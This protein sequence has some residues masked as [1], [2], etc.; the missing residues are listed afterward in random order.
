MSFLRPAPSAAPRRLCQPPRAPLLMPAKALW[1][2]PPLELE[3]VWTVTPKPCMEC[4]STDASE[5]SP[6]DLMDVAH[7]AEEVEGHSY[8]EGTDA[9]FS[10]GGTAACNTLFHCPGQASAGF[11]STAQAC[12]ANFTSIGPRHFPGCKYSNMSPLLQSVFTQLTAR[13]IPPTTPH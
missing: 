5:G 11:G 13:S 7:E 4:C 2:V 8:E 12:T 10:R 9:V 3:S 6:R 1:E